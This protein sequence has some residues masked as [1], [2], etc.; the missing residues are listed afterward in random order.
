MRN[1]LFSGVIVLVTICSPA[2]SQA[3]YPAGQNPPTY[4]AGYPYGQNGDASHPDGYDGWP[5][6][7]PDNPNPGQAGNGGNGHGSGSGGHGGNGADGG[8]GGRGGNSGPNGGCGGT[9]GDGGR[10]GQGGI[11]G[12]GGDGGQGVQC[13]GK[14]GDG[15][16]G[17]A[18]GGEGGKGGAATGPGG[19][20]GDGGTG[21]SATDEGGQ[22]GNGGCGGAA[23]GNGSSGGNG[24]TGGWAT[25]PQGGEGGDG[26]CGGGSTG[27]GG[28]GGDAGNGGNANT[29]PGDP[30]TPGS[31]NG[32]PPGEDD[33]ACDGDAGTEGERR[34]PMIAKAMPIRLVDLYGLQNVAVENGLGLEQIVPSI[35][36][37]RGIPGPGIEIGVRTPN[38]ASPLLSDGSVRFDLVLAPES[39]DTE[40]VRVA[41]EYRVDGASPSVSIGFGADGSIV[42]APSVPVPIGDGWLSR[43]FTVVRPQ[44][45]G[46]L[47]HRLDLFAYHTR[48]VEVRLLAA[49]DLGA[50]GDVNLDQIVDIHDL[51]VVA[52]NMFTAGDLGIEQGDT[53]LNG[54]IDTADLI[55]V[56]DG[57]QP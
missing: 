42:A 18:I 27:F 47:G 33:G 17:G 26:G 19:Q 40:R 5:A 15:G 52:S 21:G 9:G 14:G 30:G 29:E 28:C 8:P 46:P 55:T 23:T 50:R 38:S 20:G 37:W 43:E 51:A 12:D 2:F 45:G 25:N 34:L 32:P 56:I 7:H 13:G 49:R 24:G 16:S 54:V 57:M 4:P 3:A 48:D 22:A 44:A 11:G 10:S 6:D 35:D 31:G 36:A 39:L 41:V 1:V 53:D